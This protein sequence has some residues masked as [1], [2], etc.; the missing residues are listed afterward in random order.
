MEKLNKCDNL[1][2]DADCQSMNH[3][4]EWVRDFLRDDMQSQVRPG[5]KD[6][7]GVDSR[8][9][10]ALLDYFRSDKTPIVEAL[11][12]IYSDEND[13]E[14]EI[15]N[16]KNYCNH[17]IQFLTY[18]K[19]NSAYLIAAILGV[20]AV[21]SIAIDIIAPK[22]SVVLGV[23]LTASLTALV[24]GFIWEEQKYHYEGKLEELLRESVAQR[25]A[26]QKPAHTNKAI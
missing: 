15:E 13:L 23:F 16:L 2:G 12:K 21:I 25:S 9:H 1:L 6:M 3:V 18:K 8:S 4:T 20:M 19:I 24:T 17:K 10:N 14:G 26:V 22:A 5:D 7:R 11:K